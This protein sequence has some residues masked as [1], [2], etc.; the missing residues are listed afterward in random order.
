[1][2]PAMPRPV[3]RPMRALITWIAHISG[4][5]NTS[6]GQA[7]AELGAGL[8]IGGDAAGSSSEAPVIR[9][10]PMISASFGR[11]AV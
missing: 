1:M 11:Q 9:P 3:T 8:G 7:E 2:L 10:G 4:Q 6:P 5:E